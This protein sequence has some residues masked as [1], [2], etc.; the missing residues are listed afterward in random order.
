MNTTPSFVW[1]NSGKRHTL[2]DA[3]R[4]FCKL[5]STLRQQNI[6]ILMHLEINITSVYNLRLGASH[7]HKIWSSP[8]YMAYRNTATCF[9]KLC[10]RVDHLKK[11]AT[12]INVVALKLY[13]A[14]Q[15]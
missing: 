4:V 8:E 5:F 6:H 15:W 10:F 12:Y 9:L 7:L 1:K 14:S 11:Y 2:Y 3:Y 13:R